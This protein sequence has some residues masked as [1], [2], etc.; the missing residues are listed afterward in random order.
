MFTR[1]YC[2][3]IDFRVDDYLAANDL[4]ISVIET[5]K[6][7]PYHCEKWDRNRRSWAEEGMQVYDCRLQMYLTVLTCRFQL[8]PTVRPAHWN[9]KARLD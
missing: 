2:C 4:I 7:D 5:V 9:I 8:K 3:N 1:G 6:T